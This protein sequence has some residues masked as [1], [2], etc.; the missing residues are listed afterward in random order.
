MTKFQKTCLQL[1]K[2]SIL[3]EFGKA[4]ASVIANIMKQSEAEEFEKQWAC[5]V[6]LKKNG[7]LRGCIGTIIPHRPLGEDIRMNGWYAAFEDPRF[8]PLTL[9]EIENNDFHMGIT[10]LSPMQDK[11]FKKP[12]ELI[13][14]L[15]KERCGLV[16]KFGYR[17]ATFLPS[18]R[19]E[20]SDPQEFVTH[21]LRKAWINPSEFAKFFKEFGFQ[22]YYGEEFWENRKKI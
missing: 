11:T 15:D 7:E 18:V 19:E 14:F 21:L 22:V 16:I 17:Q 6:T 13:T 20:L 4:D 10:I 3:E 8:P 2:S 5:F 9:D 1:A 12:E